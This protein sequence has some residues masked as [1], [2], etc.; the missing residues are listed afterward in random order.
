MTKRHADKTKDESCMQFY[1]QLKSPFGRA[2]DKYCSGDSAKYDDCQPEYMAEEFCKA[3][4]NFYNKLELENNKYKTS[5]AAG[6]LR[7]RQYYTHRQFPRRL[8]CALHTVRDQLSVRGKPVDALRQADTVSM[9]Q[10]AVS[11]VDSTTRIDS[12]KELAVCS[13]RREGPTLR[14]REAR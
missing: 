8:L 7:S 2:G 12:S 3:L 5:Q 11:A 1:D 4:M 10:P 14:A 6:S 9:N 13:A